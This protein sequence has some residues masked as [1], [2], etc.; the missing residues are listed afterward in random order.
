MTDSPSPPPLP[1]DFAVPTAHHW[2]KSDKPEVFIPNAGTMGMWLLLV[3][4]G[5]LFASSVV[6]YLALRFVKFAG[7]P[8]PPY[9]FPP[10]PRSLWLST[11]VIL[12][13]SVTIHLA[14][15]AIRRDRLPALRRY[16]LLTLGLGVAFLV[17]QLWNWWSLYAALPPQF[18]SQGGYFGV[19]V[20][21]TGLH[22]VH[23]LGGLIPLGI[24]WSRARGAGSAVYYSANF[25]P[26]VRY[27]TMY[28]HFLDL[29]WLTLFIV[30]YLI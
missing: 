18:V 16:L 28:W 19:F 14:L 10:L 4:L 25:H 15:A 21:L 27:C 20:V 23:V 12:S 6:A 2:I 30:V 1:R 7:Q 17:L 3:A 9:G 5:M 13:A 29:V 24:V 11:V 8:W 22:A 26:G